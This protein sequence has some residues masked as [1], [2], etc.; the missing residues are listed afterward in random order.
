MQVLKALV[1]YV[2]QQACSQESVAI[3]IRDIGEFMRAYPHGRDI[4]GSL[5]LK[6]H[7]MQLLCCKN[8]RISTE[9]LQVLQ[10]LVAS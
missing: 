9:A 7:L 2:E 4:V 3:A 8:E 5:G 6:Q 1:N 10:M